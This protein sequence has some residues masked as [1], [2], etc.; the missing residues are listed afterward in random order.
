MLLTDAGPSTGMSGCEVAHAA[1]LLPPAPRALFTIAFAECHRAWRP[2]GSQ[3]APG[4]GPAQ[5]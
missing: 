2:A 1:H 5:A 4:S 3:G